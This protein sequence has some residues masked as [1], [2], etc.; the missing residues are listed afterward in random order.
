MTFNPFSHAFLNQLYRHQNLME[1]KCITKMIGQHILKDWTADNPIYN[2][3]TRMWIW[4]GN[5]HICK[6]IYEWI[7]FSNLSHD[8]IFIENNEEMLKIAS[9]L[10]HYWNQLC[11]VRWF[12]CHV[13]V[14]LY[15]DNLLKYALTQKDQACK[16]M[17]NRRMQIEKFHHKHSN[18]CSHTC[19]WVS[20]RVRD[21]IQ[22]LLRSTW[23]KP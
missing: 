4:S 18:N 13:V 17:S 15:F 6:M 20:S 3:I 10:I 11:S 14:S 22:V 9:A 8:R 1:F 21:M 5:F 23:L 7:K 16:K 2:A 12:V 19:D